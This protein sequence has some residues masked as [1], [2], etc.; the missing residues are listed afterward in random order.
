MRN[1][2]L[3]MLTVI[4]LLAAAAP[5]ASEDGAG[6]L[7]TEALTGQDLY[8]SGRELMSYQPATDAHILLF[9]KKFSMSI[10]AN[11]YSSDKAVVWLESM[12]IESGGRVHIDYLAK[13]YLEGNLSVRRGQG[14]RTSGLRQTVIK[15]RGKGRLIVVRFGVSGEVFV[16][17]D[18]REI[19]DPRE[20]GLYKNALAAVKSTEPEY[21]IQPEAQVPEVPPEEPPKEP[22]VLTPVLDGPVTPPEQVIKP[23]KEK[24]RFMYPVNIAPAG[25]AALDI[26]SARTADGTDIA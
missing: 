21:F 22:V 14:A 10:G 2:N 3:L 13:V 7:S 1:N 20:S 4:A 8:L 16:T 23:D 19:A 18:K 25:E 11:R 15:Q 5:A 26:E 17:A 24:P 12:T 6:G 9:E